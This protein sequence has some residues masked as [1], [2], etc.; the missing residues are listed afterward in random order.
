[1]RHITTIAAILLGGLTVAAPAL[2][3]SDSAKDNKGQARAAS[4]NESAKDNTRQGRAASVSNPAS[5]DNRGQARADSVRAV[6]AQAQAQSDNA[7]ARRRAATPGC[8]NANPR[9]Q[10]HRQGRA[11]RT[12]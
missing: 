6:Q 12:Y 1:M 5:Q 7:Q 3:A 11:C 2:A 8:A 9:S 4:V 10:G